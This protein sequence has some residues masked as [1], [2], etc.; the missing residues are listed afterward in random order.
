MNEFF[1]HDFFADPGKKRKCLA[2]GIRDMGPY[3]KYPVCRPDPLRYDRLVWWFLLA[4]TV[5]VAVYAFAT[6]PE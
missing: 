3:A 2:C 4:V 5:A 1:S 6:H